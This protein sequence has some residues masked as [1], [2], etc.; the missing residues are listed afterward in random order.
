MPILKRRVDSFP[1][2]YLSSVSWKI[3]PLYFF[4]SNN[5]YFAQKEPIKKKIFET[6][7]CSGQILSNSL[8]QFWNGKSIPFQI[9]YP[10][11][12]SWKIILL[13]CTCLAQT[14]YTLLKRSALKW[15]FFRFSR[16]RVKFYQIPYA[17]FE[18]TSPLLSKFCNPLQFHERLFLCTF[19]AQTIYTL[20][21]SSSNFASFFIV[22]T[23]NSS[24]DFKLILFLLWIKGSDQ[25]PNFETFN[26]SGENLPYSSCHFPNHKSVFLQIL[27][28]PSVS[29]KITPLYFFRSNIKYFAHFSLS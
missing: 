22:M 17:N 1:I 8:C 12:V 16:A 27:H 20:L 14:I 26:C 15:K 7:E 13:F 25:Y 11:S 28:H 21:N 23:H 24:V 9:L 6:F 2:L 29:W 3:I 10:S 4:S 19:L 5:I 18:T